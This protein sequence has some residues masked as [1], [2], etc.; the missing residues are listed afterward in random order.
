VLWSDPITGPGLHDN[1]ARGCGTVWG[2]DVTEVW[3]TVDTVQHSSTSGG[4]E[5]SVCG[6]VSWRVAVITSGL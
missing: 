4:G 5:S 2:P 3:L 1:E 6:V